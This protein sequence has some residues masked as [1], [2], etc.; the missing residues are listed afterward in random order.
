MHGFASPSTELDQY[1]QLSYRRRRGPALLVVI[2]DGGDSRQSS[3]RES[4]VYESCIRSGLCYRVAVCACAMIVMLAGLGSCTTP[5]GSQT[6]GGSSSSS[7][8]VGDNTSGTSA[9]PGSKVAR[10]AGG[11]SRYEN[12]VIGFALDFEPR[13]VVWG[14]VADMRPDFRDS[15]QVMEQ[16]GQEV[17]LAAHL[18][19]IVGCRVTTENLNVPVDDYAT[20]IIDINKSEVD[21]QR[22]TRVTIAGR[23]MVEWGATHPQTG[24]VFVEYIALESGFNLRMTFWTHPSLLERYHPEFRK[25]VASL[26]T[27]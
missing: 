10:T 24:L 9:K 17:L 2:R 26:R 21:L 3:R 23:D 20:V 12:P 15:I 13:W 5:G 16:N 22:Q 1:T 11:T 25:V 8:V 14:R 6:S 19:N 18:N 4:V 7:G 27:I